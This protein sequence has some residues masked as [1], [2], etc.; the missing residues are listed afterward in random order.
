MNL[1]EISTREK[2]RFPY[3][4]Q[5]SVEDL[6]DVSATGLDGIFKALKA[7]AKKS[8]EEGLLS[9][10]TSA[11][12][13]LDNKIEIV[14]YIFGVKMAEKAKREEAVKRKAEKEK[15]LEILSEKEDNALKNLS[16]DELRARIAAME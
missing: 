6:W 15:L 8:D 10:K 13:E 4:G 5:I 12:T 7:Q 2:Y 11:D 1:F 9:H 3:K 14:R 16:I